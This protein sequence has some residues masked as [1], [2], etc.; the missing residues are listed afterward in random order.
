MSC[1]SCDSKNRYITFKSLTFTSRKCDAHF[2]YESL[3]AVYVNHKVCFTSTK[4]IQHLIR[5][6][7]YLKIYENISLI[8]RYI[9][10]VG[11]FPNERYEKG[12]GQINPYCITW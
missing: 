2:V 6:W 9:F 4:I 8:S 11:H 7:K 1:S 5:L 10:S 12:A 3:D